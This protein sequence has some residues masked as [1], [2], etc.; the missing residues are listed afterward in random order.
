MPLLACPAVGLC[1][2]LRREIGAG[3]EL[4]NRRN[5][6]PQVF[7]EISTA[8]AADELSAPE[9]VVLREWAIARASKSATQS[10]FNDILAETPYSRRWASSALCP[11]LDES[12]KRVGAINRKPL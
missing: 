2:G 11:R 1:Q 9:R 6:R 4:S 12:S 5:R 10:E 3:I 7:T 8:S